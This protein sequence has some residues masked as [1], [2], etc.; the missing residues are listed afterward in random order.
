MVVRLV[1]DNAVVPWLVNQRHLLDHQ[2]WLLLL[3][4]KHALCRFLVKCVSIHK[5][6]ILIHEVLNIMVVLPDLGNLKLSQVQIQLLIFYL[7]PEQ[8]LVPDVVRFWLLKRQQLLLD[9]QFKCFQVI[10]FAREISLQ[11]GQVVSFELKPVN[12]LMLLLDP[13][14]QLLF[15]LYL[16]CLVIYACHEVEVATGLCLLILYLELV[17][18][19]FYLLVQVVDLVVQSRV[20]FLFHL[21][22][23]SNFSIFVIK[24]KV[25][26]V[27]NRES[28][29]GWV[30][31]SILVEWV[32]YS[33]QHHV[34]FAQISDHV[35]LV[36]VKILLLLQV[37]VHPIQQTLEVYFLL[38]QLLL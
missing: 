22:L 33:A 3:T 13:F 20:C 29:I 28:F 16:S 9:L 2:K 10:D 27:H 12:A 14:F 15:V 5:R 8:V 26:L 24:P 21:E 37:F 23:L 31:K 32:S 25:V 1:P 17:L 19:H 11:D 4:L 34:F 30:I 38:F 7:Q 6:L 18:Q 36:C 35:L